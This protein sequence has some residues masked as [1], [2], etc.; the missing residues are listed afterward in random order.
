M[1]SGKLNFLGFPDHDVYNITAPFLWMGRVIIA[2]RVEKREEE[3]SRIVFF[4]E[5][6]KGWYPVKSA[7]TFQ[8]LQDPCISRIDGKILL[9]G[10]RFPVIFGENKQGW[11]MEFFLED[12][13]GDFK[14]GKIGSP[15]RDW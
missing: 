1:N 3:I 11:Q 7:P 6:E 10:V 8:G 9:G 15:R 12:Q 2:G 13:D 5:A 4:E 14:K